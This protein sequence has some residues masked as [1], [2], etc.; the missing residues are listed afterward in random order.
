MWAL[1]IWKGSLPSGKKCF[2]NA[3][4]VISQKNFCIDLQ[5]PFRLRR[6]VEPNQ[7]SQMSLIAWQCH[8][9][10]LFF[11][12]SVCHQS[13]ACYY[14]SISCFCSMHLRLI[15]HN[16]SRLE[17]NS[18]FCFVKNQTIYK[19][20]IVVVGFFSPGYR[21][22]SLRNVMSWSDSEMLLFLPCL[23]HSSVIPEPVSFQCC[24]PSRKCNK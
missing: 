3:I 20:V 23:S 18:W 19:L 17:T 22:Q 5:S 15:L 10:F 9:F 4:N 7:C 14:I 11:F 8:R 21:Y 6:Q 16:G 24:F 2:H 13:V 1:S 12:P